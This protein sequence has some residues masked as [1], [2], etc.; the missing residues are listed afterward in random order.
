MVLGSIYLGSEMDAG[1]GVVSSGTGSTCI[2]PNAALIDVGVKGDSKA[3]TAGGDTSRGVRSGNGTLSSSGV[4]V[5]T[6]AFHDSRTARP[7]ADGEGG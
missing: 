6:S 2:S 5:G 7:S 1:V 4:S 3:L